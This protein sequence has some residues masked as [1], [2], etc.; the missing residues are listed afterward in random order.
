M[1]QVHGLAQIGNRNVKD[2]S[3]NYSFGEITYLLLDFFFFLY[4][5]I[6]RFLF[7]D[8]KLLNANRIYIYFFHQRV[9]DG[10]VPVW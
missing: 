1:F 3:F 7:F 6:V 5:F 10:R 8:V 9:K 2:M 4:K